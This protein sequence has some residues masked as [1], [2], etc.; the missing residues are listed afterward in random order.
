MAR[1]ILIK[2]AIMSALKVSATPELYD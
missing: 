2:Q 1:L